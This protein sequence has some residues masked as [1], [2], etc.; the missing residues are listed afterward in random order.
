MENLQTT[1]T[2][3]EWDGE[4]K[5]VLEKVTRIEPDGFRRIVETKYT[6]NEHGEE[7]ESLKREWED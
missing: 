5:I 7:I 1:H 6:Y 4:G 2:T 3:T